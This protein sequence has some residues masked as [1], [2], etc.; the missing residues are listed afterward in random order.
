MGIKYG[1][2]VR[3]KY[4]EYMIDK[5]LIDVHDENCPKSIR[6]IVTPDS[7]VGKNLF[8]KEVGDKYRLNIDNNI[9]EIEIVEIDKGGNNI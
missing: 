7:I 8:N 5:W 6:D 2:F 4:N 9:V 1:D 3:F